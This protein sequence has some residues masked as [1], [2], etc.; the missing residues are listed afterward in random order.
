MLGQKTILLVDDDVDLREMLADELTLR[1]AYRV[2]QCGTLREAEALALA[3]D[4]R[5]DAIILDLDLP[6]GDGRP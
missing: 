4:N 1:C 6:D 2:K 5:L 3:L